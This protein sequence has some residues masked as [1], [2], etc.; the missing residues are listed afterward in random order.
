M[1]AGGTRAAALS[2]GVLQEL[3]DTPV[4]A[5]GDRPVES[6]FII[7]D[8]DGI[9]DPERRR[10]LNQIPTSFQLSDE[11]VDLLIEAGGVLLRTN[12]EFQRLLTDLGKG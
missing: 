12:P 9:Q 11:Q 1:L 3:R 6:Y 7:L 8:F 2:Y 10:V 4:P 5:T